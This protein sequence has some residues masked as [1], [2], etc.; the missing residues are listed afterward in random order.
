M[1]SAGFAGLMDDLTDMVDDGTIVETQLPIW[2]AVEQFGFRCGEYLEI[3][4]W[5]ASR[6]Q[7]VSG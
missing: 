1:T 4:D 6:S 2:G 3:A 7:Q 5:L